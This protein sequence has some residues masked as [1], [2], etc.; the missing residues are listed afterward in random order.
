ML[1]DYQSYLQTDGYKVSDKIGKRPR[2][3][4]V[5]CWAYSA[6]VNLLIFVLV[7]VYQ[8]VVGFKYVLLG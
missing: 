6:I 1:C 7:L 2:I 8:G 3:K 4:L 5:G